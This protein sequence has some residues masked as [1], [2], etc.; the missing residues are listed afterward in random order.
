MQEKTCSACVIILHKKLRW[1]GMAVSLRLG[2]GST[3]EVAAAVAASSYQW[4]SHLHCSKVS[5]MLLSGL[6][7][8]GFC[9][10]VGFLC[11]GFGLGFF[12]ENIFIYHQLLPHY[13]LGFLWS[14]RASCGSLCSFH[15]N[16]CHSICSFHFC[17]RR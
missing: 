1:H 3:L 15:W 13:I 10:V 5:K 14:N 4:Q 16:C 17:V 9:F 2:L 8:V 11:V 6:G 12:S 7:L